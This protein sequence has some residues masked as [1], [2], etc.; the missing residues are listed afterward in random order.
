MA[1]FTPT[2]SQLEA[3]TL[4][5]PALLVAAGA[6]SG[7]TRVLTERVLR[8]V[9]DPE[10]G[11][12]LDSFLVISFTRAAAAELRGR[13]MEALAARLAADPSNRRLRRQS[14][15]LSRAQ[16]GTIH[17][18]CAQLLR[19][20]CQAAGLAPDFRILDE[21]RARAMRS[22]A[23]DR[24]LEEAYD[25]IDNDPDFRLLADTAGEG[26]DDRALEELVL[27]LHSRMQCHARPALWAEEQTALLDRP[28][29]DAGETPWGRELLDWAKA[30]A[31]FHAANS[32]KKT[33]AQKE[34]TPD[35]R[36]RNLQ[37][38]FRADPEKTDVSSVI[39]VDDIYTTGSTAEACTR[40]LKEAG[41][42]K[43]FTA[44]L[45]IVPEF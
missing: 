35:Q 23:L 33:E 9:C 31:D 5:G 38:A 18:F 19:E 4:R 13:I 37:K 16:I 24:A 15:L 8:A 12:E 34:L 21:D 3:M 20:N 6:G 45:C 1:E 25:G 30:L 7:K 28:F 27:T 44:C 17:S 11:A 2:P 10:A 41:V 32:E 39:L 40:A 22:A 29:S 36:I 14:A 42:R 26:R 43:V